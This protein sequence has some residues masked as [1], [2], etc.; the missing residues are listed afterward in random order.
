MM[1]QPPFP[2]PSRTVAEL[3]QRIRSLE[4]GAAPT[5]TAIW[6]TGSRALDALFPL[7][8]IRPGSLVEWVE[9]GPASGAG[10]LS[11][12]V[13]RQVGRA[14]RP[15]V[16]I[17]SQQQVYPASMAALGFDLSRL[18]IVRPTT[19]RGTLW[20]CEETLHSQAV[21]IVW[22]R[23]EHVSSTAARRLR[24][25]AEASSSVCFLLR[26]H[27]ALRQP[28]WAEVRLVVEPLPFRNESP[29]YRISVAYSQGRT[30]LSTTD[31]Q[32]DRLRGTI[33][34]FFPATTTNSL[35]LVS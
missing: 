11:L 17:D 23:A 31:I 20:A 10:T 3:Q 19:D 1:I 9:T 15:F 14:Q 16:V 34:E 32:I 2:E 30:L 8:G 24:L 29:G 28:S 6:G 18:V 27:Q 5:Q 22:A 12:L 7:Q 26:P 21:E 25:A 35:S 4:R 33:D 13:S